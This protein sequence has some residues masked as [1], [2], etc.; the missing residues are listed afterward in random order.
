MIPMANTR[1][2]YFFIVAAALIFVVLHS[3][4]QPA[5]AY[6]T[7]SRWTTDGT[8]W[9]SSFNSGVASPP[10]PSNTYSQIVT[11]GDRWSEPATGR[12][13]MFANYTNIV[14]PT[15]VYVDKASFS[16]RG[17]PSYPGITMVG[18][19][20]GHLD[21]GTIYLN[22]DWSWNTSCILSQSQHQVD[23]LTVVLHEMGH[24]VSLNHDANHPEAVMWPD[25][26]CKQHLSADEL[27]GIGAMYPYRLHIPY[28]IRPKSS[29]DPYP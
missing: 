6:I 26:A 19:S 14:G 24:V 29:P 15:R 25:Y 12:N 21:Y 23:V 20:N 16:V 13:Y 8:E 2:I 10:F 1:R 17:F 9:R 22:S 11:A 5:K 18:Y 3:R 28:V 27:D 4:A 7:V